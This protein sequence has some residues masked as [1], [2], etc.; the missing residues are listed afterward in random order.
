MN[1]IYYLVIKKTLLLY[2]I[3]SQNLIMD[4]F[5]YDKNLFTKNCGNITSRN[6]NIMNKRTE[7]KNS[8][9]SATP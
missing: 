6:Y 1:L 8:S 7:S 2:D 5:K 9:E 3:I 4:N